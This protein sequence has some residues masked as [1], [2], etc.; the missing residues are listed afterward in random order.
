M[1]CSCCDRDLSDKE[2]IW[3]PEIDNW[4]LC[5]TCLDVAMET[6]YTGGFNRDELDDKF[7][8]LDEDILEGSLEQYTFQRWFTD[9]YE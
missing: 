3:N 6:A 1:K 9:D 5:T 4:E 7:V 8:L 2:I